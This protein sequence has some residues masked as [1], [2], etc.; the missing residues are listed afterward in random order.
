MGVEKLHQ[1]G[2]VGKRAGEAVHLVDNDDIDLPAAHVIEKRLKSRPDE[3][4][5]REGAIIKVIGNE[6]PAL[7]G[8]ALDIGLAGLALCVEGVEGQIEIMICGLARV[9]GAAHRLDNRLLHSALLTNA[10]ED[11][12]RIDERA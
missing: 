8:L 11:R 5:P 10:F 9:D 7:M 2:E 12:E 1:F 6:L 4:S 3:R